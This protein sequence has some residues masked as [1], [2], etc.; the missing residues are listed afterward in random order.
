M[1]AHGIGRGR[2]FTLMGRVPALYAAP[3]GAFKAGLVVSPLFAAFGP[4]PVGSR[5]DIGEASVLATTTALY[6]RKVVD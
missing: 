6:Q 1:A 4:E 2:L 5:M 3:L